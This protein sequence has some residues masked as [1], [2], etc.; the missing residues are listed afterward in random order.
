[1]IK[2]ILEEIALQ[3]GTNEKMKTLKK[4]KENNLLKNVIYIALSKR[5]KFY[6]RQIPQYECSEKSM[7]LTW[8][9][10]KLKDI[11]NREVT[12]ND[13]IDYLKWILSSVS[14]DDAY[15]IERI[16]E[17]DLKIGMGQTN[18]NKIIPKL[19]EK[20]PYMG[21]SSFE[22]KLARD[23][24]KDGLAYSQI[25]MDGRYCN[26][27]IEEG[28]VYLESRSGEETYIPMSNL[29][30]ALRSFPKNCVLNGELTIDGI[31]R[32]ESNGIINSVISISKKLKDGSDAEKDKKH[33][34]ARHNISY[35]EALRQIKYTVWDMVQIEEYLDGKS[36]FDYTSRLMALR[37]YLDKMDTLNSI[38]IIESKKVKTYAEAIAHFQ[39]A[40]ARG[41]EGTILKSTMGQWKDGKPKWQVKM[42]L[43]ID[44]DMKIIGFNYGTRGTKNEN[45]ISSINVESSC[46]LVKT[47]PT[48]ITEADMKYITKNHKELL[49]SVI[50]M[51]CSG[52]SH[53]NEGNYS[54]L[55]PVFKV[56]R[57]DK[58]E[59][60]SLEEIK[61]IET[62]VKTL[63]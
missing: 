51:K 43:E 42:K 59:A 53:D 46:G 18:I 8:A 20:T 55:H 34:L 12:G 62:M 44:L 35:E 63:K 16:I 37:G 3:S 14:S 11:S 40:L 56:L 32:N 7:D 15:V 6:I 52:L 58:Y 28:N 57:D 41:E 13:A 5:V 22:E 25:K 23:I 61:K 19:I 30:F 10:E 1:M 31:D 39:E 38:R 21:A 2:S 9:I 60:N 27:I 36:K 48:G 54:T 29:V 50:S 26:A 33:I 4:Y 24:L 47:R 45:L 49:G 17:K